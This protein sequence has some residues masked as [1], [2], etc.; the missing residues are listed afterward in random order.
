MK[1]LKYILSLLFFCTIIFY[2]C[3]K[4]EPV[5]PVPPA[6]TKDTTAQVKLQDV[7]YPN[8]CRGIFTI[9]TNITDTQNVLILDML[10]R[11]KLNINIYGTTAIVDTSLSN[12]VYIVHL[13][14]K[15]GIFQSKLIVQK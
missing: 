12:G 4:D 2:S 15:A 6:Q 3:K 9:S 14:G 1:M 7:I 11:T 5:Y 10:G 13:S 8:P